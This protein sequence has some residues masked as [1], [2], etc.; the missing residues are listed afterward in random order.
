MSTFSSSLRVGG[1]TLPNR[2]IMAPLTRM[3]AGP[4]RVPTERMAEYYTQ[5]ASAGLII[6]EATSV[7]PQGVGYPNTPGIWSDEQVAGWK[8]VTDA[9]HRHGGR[10]VLQLWHVGRI[11][12][13][14]LLDGELPVAPSAIAAEGDVSVLRPKRPYVT[15]RAL[16]L[17]EIPGI[18]A[19]YR[20]GAENAKLAGFDGVELHGAN[21]YLL[22]QFLQ[23]STN[24]RDDAYGG[25]IENRARLLLEATDAAIAVWGADHVGVHLSPQGKSHSISDS[26]PAATFGYVARE[27]GRR[28]VAFLCIR[29]PLGDSRLLPRIKQA[30]GGV[31]FA[32]DGFTQDTGATVLRAGEADAV[33][34][35]VLFIANPDLP[36]RFELNAPLN[37]PN[38][39][40][41]YSGTEEGYTDYPALQAA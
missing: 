39:S 11:S 8:K 31:V 7:T 37:T 21:G 32:N 28:K 15:P 14:S 2:V 4:G 22:D 33:A 41:F 23:D 13:P 24:K 27:M 26:D 18:V 6:T 29:E 34:Y 40:T 9:V 17:D 36:K 12:D 5:R 19:A 10:I 16:R 38:P 1:L 20:K 35:G 25:S 3:Q 30:F